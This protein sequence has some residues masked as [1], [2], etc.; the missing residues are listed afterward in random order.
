ML[1]CPTANL[2]LQ[3]VNA[4][5]TYNYNYRSEMIIDLMNRKFVKEKSTSAIPIYQY[6]LCIKNRTNSTHNNFPSEFRQQ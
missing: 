3:L 6:S 2:A 4:F 5:Y 1:N